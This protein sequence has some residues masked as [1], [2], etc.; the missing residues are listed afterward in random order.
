MVAL[1]TLKYWSRTSPQLSSQMFD[2]NGHWTSPQGDTTG[3]LNLTVKFCSTSFILCPSTKHQ[4]RSSSPTKTWDGLVLPHSPQKSIIYKFL[5]D[6][7]QNGSLLSLLTIITL[8]MPQV[9]IISCLDD[10]NDLRNLPASRLIPRESAISTVTKYKYLK[11][12]SEPFTPR[13]KI[14]LVS[15]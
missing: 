14:L 7:S 10:C 1:K 5:P 9:L 11:Y 3:I 2:M 13:L 6:C 4:L 8:I 15:L 12:K